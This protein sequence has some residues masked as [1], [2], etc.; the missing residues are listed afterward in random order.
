MDQQ[1]LIVG[2][3]EVQRLERMFEKI[4]RLAQDNRDL[5]SRGYQAARSVLSTMDNSRVETYSPAGLVT[6][7]S[8]A[9][10]VDEVI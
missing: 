7:R 6:N 9:R 4:F 1:K 5:L 3:H 8:A 10:L 2:Q